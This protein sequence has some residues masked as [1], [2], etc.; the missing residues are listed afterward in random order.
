[1]EERTADLIVVGA[2]VLGT[3]HAYFAAKRGL[4]VLLLER[5]EMPSDASRRNFGMVKRTVVPTTGEWIAHAHATADIYRQIQCEID[6]SIQEDGSLYLASTEPERAVLVEFAQRYSATYGCELLDARQA[7]ER[8]PFIRAEYCAE[9]LFF[10]QDL[11]VEPRTLLKRLIPHIVQTERI[12][13]V[14]RTTIVSV[15]ADGH[16]CNVRSARGER[17]S[18]DRVVICS[19]AEYRTLFPALF[20]SSGLRICKLQM[21]RTVSLP[22]VLPHSILSGLSIA[23][24]PAFADCPSY[25]NLGRSNNGELEEYGIHLLLKQASDGSVIIGDSHEYRDIFE[26]HCLEERTNPAINEAILRYARGMV[27]L[28]SWAIAE[29]WNGYYLQHPDKLIYTET[30][31]ER[32]HIVTGIAGKGMSTGAGFARASVGRLLA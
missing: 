25:A 6:I 27:R 23:R 32:I 19:G 15:E 11:T 5:N 4:S 13:Y 7:R 1:M 16:T 26:A 29:L 24:Y 28:P 12:V 14:P 9:A 21:M 30:I 31:D 18:A 17:F 20:R 3:F 8:Y 22:P 2:G 10:P